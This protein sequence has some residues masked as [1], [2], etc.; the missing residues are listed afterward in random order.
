MISGSF[1]RLQ[2]ARRAPSAPWREVIFALAVIPPLDRRATL[3][4]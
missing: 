2:F 4:D 3:I 1:F